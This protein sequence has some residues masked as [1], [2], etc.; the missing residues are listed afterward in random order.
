MKT[1]SMLGL[2]ALAAMNACASQSGAAPA[3]SSNQSAGTCG[4]TETPC[5]TKPDVAKARAHLAQHV[6]YPTTRAA[7]LAACAMTPEFT[8]AEKQWLADNLPE[9]KYASPDDVGRA[10]KL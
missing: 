6:N 10:L 2:I 9:G 7:I 1:L 5:A 8:A 3:A 4:V